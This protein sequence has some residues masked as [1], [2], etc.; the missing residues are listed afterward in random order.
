MTLDP[1]DFFLVLFLS[2]LVIIPRL[3]F[4]AKSALRYVL[5]CSK[6]RRKRIT[7]SYHQRIRR[8]SSC[9]RLV[10]QR[11]K[12]PPRLPVAPTAPRTPKLS[13]RSKKQRRSLSLGRCPSLSTRPPD[14]PDSLGF[15]DSPNYPAPRHRQ[16]LDPTIVDDFLSSVHPLEHYRKFSSDPF[17][18]PGPSLPR[19]YSI[20]Y[21]ASSHDYFAVHQFGA[22]TGDQSPQPGSPTDLP[23][24]QLV[25]E[26]PIVIDT[27][28]SWSVT[29][30][31]KDFVSDIKPWAHESLQSLDASIPVH[32]IGTVEWTVQDQ[33]KNVRTFRTTALYVP[34]AEVRL[35]SPQVY[36][37]ETDSGSLFCYKDRLLLTLL[38]GSVL[39]FPWHPHSNIPFM[40]TAEMY[41]DLH[42][43]QHHCHHVLNTT[44][45]DTIL[46]GD[47]LPSVLD[48]SNLN[49]TGSQKELLLWHQRLGHCSLKH[50]QHLLALPR[51]EHSRQVLVPHNPR[52]STCDHPRCDACQYAKQKRRSSSTALKRP[53]VEREGGIS[54]NVLTPGQ[55]VSIDLYQSSIPGRLPHTKGH[56]SVSQKYAGG[57]IFY[58]IA[59]KYVFVK[60]QSNLTGGM[61]VNSKHA[62]ESF[63]N[64]FGISIKEYLTDNHP[65]RSEVFVQDCINLGQKQQLSGVGAHHQNR[66]E[67]VNQTIFNWSR[68]MMLHYIL[69]W[70]QEAHLE[71]WPFAVDYA[72]WLWNHLPD[73][74]TRLSPIEVFTSATFPDYKH[75]Q[76]TRV[77]GC[78]VFV[79]DPTLQ[80]AKKLPKWQKRSWKGIFLGFSP[81][82]HT[83]VALVLNPETGSITPQYHVIFD[84]MFS[85]IT[86]QKDDELTLQQWETL[87]DNGYDRHE[88]IEPPDVDDNDNNFQ[89][90]LPPD[91]LLPLP[92]QPRDLSPVVDNN[93]QHEAPTSV[94]PASRT[95]EPTPTATGGFDFPVEPSQD[96]TTSRRSQRSRRIPEH[97]RKDFVLDSHRPRFNLTGITGTLSKQ[98]KFSFSKTLPRFRGEVLNQ[99]RL[100]TLRWNELLTSVKK[101]TYGALLTELRRNSPDGFIEEWNPSLLATKANAE[102]HPTYE[103]AMNGP[104]AAGFK[105]A[106]EIEYNT[107]VDKDCWEVVDRPKGRSV[108]SSTWALRVKRYP[109]GSMR[110]LK[111]RFCARG[112]EQIEGLDYNE[113]FAPVV[114]W[115]TVRFLLMMSILLGLETK[116]VDYVAAFVQSNIDT[117]VY[118]EM[119]RGFAQPG[120]V[121]KLKKSLYGLKQSP[122]N[123]F[124]HLSTRLLAL[125]FQSCDADPCLF[126]TDKC[127]CL[128]YVDDTLLFARSRADIDE[129]IAGLRKQDL[130]LEEEDDVAGFLG[131]LVNRHT[132][133]SIEL[134]QEGLI[135]RVIDALQ[136]DHLPPKKTPAKLGVLSSDPE[137]EPPDGTFSYASVIGMLGYL[138][139]NSRPDISFAVSQCARFAHSPKRSHEQ[140]LERIGQ[141]LKHTKDKG[142]ILRPAPLSDTF[143]TDV[144][145]DADFAGGW[146]YEDP[147][148]PACVKSRTGFIIEI[149][150]CPIQWMSKLQTNIATST[151]EAEYTA[152]SVALRSAIPL[153]EII[154]YVTSAFCVTNSSILT[155]KTT[156]HED[157]QGALKLAQM[158][159]GRQTPR[160]KFYAIKYHWFRSWLKPN[161]IELSYIESACQKADML[162][163]SL[164]TDVFERNR[165]LSCGW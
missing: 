30:F 79:L 16:Q 124:Q 103:E 110:K 154:R 153:L 34:T 50:V 136:I 101:G 23:S 152:L 22:P 25:N 120:K 99:Q 68:A 64:E 161:Q 73:T 1:G 90:D 38:D 2:P 121:L 126:V 87:L 15:C 129:V 17:L 148:D 123:F 158:E 138:Q 67:R 128:V 132:N 65:F 5:G 141:Y 3:L 45:S 114:N 55:K 96:E 19:R 106:C 139:A 104:L 24:C 157:N 150:D 51:D 28:A 95:A 145:V 42:G 27:G 31:L 43:P 82:H 164:P 39:T 85:T 58:D 130:D 113:T 57:A 35:F 117:T 86:T 116:Q 160:S 37:Q 69:H 149:M 156:V 46:H 105:K 48:P 93:T 97:L 13:G 112:F 61:T 56:E 29:P 140:A 115:T 72:V 159:P 62:F 102:D 165:K 71:L 33:D 70:P 18:P 14:L 163:K 144:Y 4:L 12:L 26:A 20:L 74:T 146:G 40:L 91:A 78:P 118:V 11:E 9:I 36:F 32:G 109:D 135:Q 89:W 53:V 155:F 8:L 6:Y 80:D 7:L 75:L 111:A 125:G 98:T 100:S 134:L 107:L 133:G 84:E 54:N 77:F 92:I 41:A 10:K 88:D 76:R 131:V 66:V 162:T 44:V 21:F 94:E 49:L 60:H 151:M 63:A 143:T 47:P 59:S 81:K 122:L 108:I 83:N 52:A 147:N 137:G 127:I 119:P 142:L